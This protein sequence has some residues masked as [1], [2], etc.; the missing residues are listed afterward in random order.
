MKIWQ[1][2]KL[3]TSWK[4]LTSGSISRKIFGAAVTVGLLTALVKVAA[5]VKELVVAWKFGTGDTV[6]AFLIALVVPSF[7]FNVMV[8][9]LSAALIP[10]YI[11]VL[12]QEGKQTAQKLLSGVIAW[13]L[14]LLGITTILIVV[15]APVYLPWM[16]TGFDQ[17]KLDLTIHL[18]YA[19]A[20]CN[21][22]SVIIIIWG[23]VLNAGEHFAASALS[24]ILTPALTI[25]LLLEY[26]S[27]GVF[28]LAAGLVG[29]AVLEMLILGAALNRQRV[30]LLPKLYGFNAHLR[31]VTSQYLPTIAGAFLICS[32]SV[33]DQ[34]MAAMLL[35]G[36][37][38]SLNYGYRVVASPIGLISTALT[39]AVI[40][41]FSK[42]VACQDWTELRRT[43]KSYIR[44]I[45]LTSV[46]LMGLMLMFS[47]PIVQL[48]FQR[49]SFTSEDTH[50]VAQIQSF[51][52]FQIPFYL[53]NVL[54]LKLIITMGKNQILIWVTGLNLITNIVLNYLFMQWIGIQG[55]ALSTS[56]VYVFSFLFLL[57]FAN[58]ELNYKNTN[59][60][61]L[62]DIKNRN[63]K[64]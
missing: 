24:P 27:W 63:S 35:P 14:G 21:L 1:V 29:G 62:G 3:L 4:N 50:L 5:F 23:A 59:E 47:E 18:L 37:V 33:V 26:K 38:A 56:C 25:L 30:F 45:F 61:N 43:L 57:F 12:E 13:A 40:P 42:M 20:P 19:I 2:Q 55:I 8:D 54:L 7:I 10:N 49:G 22:V 52:A 41:Y 11:R 58:K 34:S 36:S 28:A 16:A 44:L 15:A 64:N 39:A 53:G 17:K 6:D 60:L 51:F 31:Q 32:S 48:V 9:P 46:P